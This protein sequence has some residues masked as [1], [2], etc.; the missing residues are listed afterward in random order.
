MYTQTHAR[1]QTNART[2]THRRAHED[3][4]PK[5]AVNSMTDAEAT[6]LPATSGFLETNRENPKQNH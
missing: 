4:R 5:G 1:T 3:A 6:A 2:Q